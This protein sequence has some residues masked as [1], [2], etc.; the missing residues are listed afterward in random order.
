MR[1]AADFSQ[2]KQQVGETQMRV[3]PFNKE[4]RAYDDAPRPS[5]LRQRLAVV[6]DSFAAWPVKHA[7]SEQQSRHVD[8]VIDRCRQLIPE[9]PRHLV[10]SA[11]RRVPGRHALALAK[12]RR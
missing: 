10:M 11:S 7:L 8:D 9:Q 2:Q 3:I 6:I 12:V 4:A 5:G 1:P